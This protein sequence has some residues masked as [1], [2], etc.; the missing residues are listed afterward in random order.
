MSERTFFSFRWAIPGITFVLLIMVI[1]YIPLLTFFDTTGFDPTFGAFV[2]FLTLLGGSPIGFLVSQL[3]WAI[4]IVIGADYWMAKKSTELLIKTCGLTKRQCLQDKR[5][6]IVV[7]DYI[8]HYD[9]QENEKELF[10]YQVRRWDILHFFYSEIIT[11]LLG[12]GVGCFLRFWLFSG[13]QVSGLDPYFCELEPKILMLISISTLIAM[14][15]LCIG[16]DWVRAQ[17]DMMYVA[18]FK[19]KMPKVPK[20]MLIDIFPKDFFERKPT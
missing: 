6:V 16:Q 9:Q 19:R 4:F 15:F 17:Y 20:R 2:A 7:F 11:L 3:W 18:I 12:L 10:K 5:K 8:I 13:I 1:N 14:I